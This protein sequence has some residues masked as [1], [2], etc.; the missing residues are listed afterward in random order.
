[1]RGSGLRCSRVHLTLVRPRLRLGASV[2][3]RACVT[4]PLPAARRTSP[5]PRTCRAPAVA[6]VTLLQGRTAPARAAPTLVPQPYLLCPI[7]IVALPAFWPPD[8]L[9]GCCVCTCAAQRHA[10][11]P[12]LP[13]A[14][15][16]L[17]RACCA[18]GQ[19]RAGRRALRARVRLAEPLGGRR[20]ARRRYAVPM[21]PRGYRCVY[22]GAPKGPQLGAIQRGVE[23]VIATPGRLNDFL[24]AQQIRLAQVLPPALTLALLAVCLLLLCAAPAA[25]E[26]SAK[27]WHNRQCSAQAVEV[28]K[29][30]AAWAPRSARRSHSCK[31]LHLTPVAAHCSLCHMPSCHDQLTQTPAQ[32]LMK[33]L[34]LAVSLL[35]A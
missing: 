25:L 2:G 18:A 21:T 16:L 8:A 11:S 26:R 17:R 30:P 23:V 14:P 31:W 10:T 13:H 3:A 29:P 22:G 12:C 6:S 7:T 1:V 4:A 24:S 9:A 5:Q 27:M 20:P 19:L 34:V 15:P 33:R 32:V 35:C 28:C